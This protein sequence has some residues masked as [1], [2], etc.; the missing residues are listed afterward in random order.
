MDILYGSRARCGS[1]VTGGVQEYFRGDFPERTAKPYYQALWEQSPSSNT[2]W[3]RRLSASPGN[4]E[5]IM[6]DISSGEGEGQQDEDLASGTAVM[7]SAF[8]TAG[9]GVGVAYANTAFR[10]LGL[11]EFELADLEGVVVQIGAREC[12]FEQQG[13]S[14]K[15]LEEVMGRCDV[16]CT[17]RPLKQ[18]KGAKEGTMKDLAD[19]VRV[20]G[21]GGGGAAD[22]GNAQDTEAGHVAAARGMTLALAALTGLL[23]HLEILGDSSNH[24]T[25]S[26]TLD[27]LQ[28]YMH[29][30]AA[31]SKAMGVFPS[32]TRFQLASALG[33][34][35]SGGLD[36]SLF[37]IL[38]K[39]CTKMGARLLRGWL[40]HPLVD[41][42][43][44]NLRQ[45]MIETISSESVLIDTLQK[46][47]GMLR[48]LPDLDK[49]M[50]RFL[51][52]PVKVTLATL[53]GVYRA[54]MR[55]SSIA[56]ALEDAFGESHQDGTEVESG[57]VL[58]RKRIIAPLQEAVSDL[59]KFQSL[60]EEVID[61]D[62]LRDSGGKQVRV[63]PQFHPELQR[64]G[65]ELSTTS[66]EMVDILR[67]V[68]KASKAPAGRIKLEFNAVHSNHLR[69]TK[70]DQGLV[71]KCRAALTLSVQKAGVLFT[72]D[73][74]RSV[75][76]RATRLS[77]QYEDVQSKIVSQ[78]LAVAG[79]YASVLSSAAKVVSEIDVLVALAVC[80]GRYEWVRPQLLPAGSQTIVIKGLRHPSVEAARGSGL[81][82]P[83]DVSMKMDSRLAIVTGPNM[84]GKSTFIRSVGIACLLAQIGSFVPASKATLTLADRICAR[85]GASDNQLRGVST[86]MAE[87][88]ETT[89]ILRKANRQSLVIVDELGR[90]TSTCDGFGIAWAVAERLISSGALCLF[91]THFHELTT[92]EQEKN[93]TG[94]QNLHVT[95]EADAASNKL[96]MLYKVTQGSCDRS[97]GIHVARL[98]HFPAHVV[99]EA[100]SLATALEN[101]EPLSAHFA[102]QPTT[103]ICLHTD[104]GQPGAR[105]KA[106]LAGPKRKITDAVDAD[107]TVSEGPPE[108]RSC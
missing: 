99:T 58:L 50:H 13:P 108:K 38:N 44:I 91:A 26:L 37:S 55:L 33:H 82:I 72:T 96:I 48:G 36:F 64:L 42:D 20:D 34:D 39:T 5:A 7:M 97:F 57:P 85:V 27:E 67:E 12:I 46:G 8:A 98:A 3:T 70:K 66:G 9:G 68:E 74:L 10:N 22:S 81:F 1:R 101:G 17:P 53:L 104:N 40:Q 6:A 105:S 24:G 78:A 86:F 52:K 43:E 4:V 92:I 106:L 51:R 94:V 65:E 56:R 79:T 61:L 49:T 45:S 54:V 84:A 75:D 41:V 30:D 102:K 28:K 87:M 16:L 31:A 103:P 88:M 2:R 83:N 93:G 25:F 100:E 63:R 11:M 60:C 59:S 35:E 47:S 14:Q 18:F 21:V 62:H 95:A 15:S 90:G 80:A 19:L 29:Y 76:A 32:P 89:A 71:G 73:R 23:R 107:S 77:D 69:V